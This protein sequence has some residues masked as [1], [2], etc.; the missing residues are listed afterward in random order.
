VLAMQSKTARAILIGVFALF[1]GVYGTRA[2][3]FLLAAKTKSL[4]L[5]QFKFACPVYGYCGFF[6]I[7]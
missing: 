6:G 2:V 4:A 7:D 5:E 3:Q 1:G